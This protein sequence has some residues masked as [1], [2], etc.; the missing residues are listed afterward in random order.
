MIAVTTSLSNKESESGVA[1]NLCSL[2]LLSPLL[3]FGIVEARLRKPLE[4]PYRAYFLGGSVWLMV[5][6]LNCTES[7]V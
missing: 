3:N 7:E 5:Q 6:E 2:W 1:E 4:Q